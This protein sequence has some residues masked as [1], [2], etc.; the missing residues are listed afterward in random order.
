MGNGLDKLFDIAEEEKLT[1]STEE[2]VEGDSGNPTGEPTSTD[3]TAPQEIKTPEGQQQEEE[4][5]EDDSALV[6]KFKELTGYEGDITDLSVEGISGVVSEIKASIAKQYAIYD[7]NPQIKAVAE[8]ISKGGKLEDF[9]QVPTPFDRA[10]FKEDNEAH[11][12]GVLRTYYKDLKNLSEEEVQEQLDFLAATP[13]KQK[14]RFTQALDAIEANAT[15]QYNDY[16]AR[17]EQDRLKAV[18]DS[19]KLN[20]II[21]A[22]KFQGISIDTKEV[23]AFTSYLKNSE[24]YD[25][26][27]KAFEADPNKV[28]LLEYLVYNDCDLSKLK[29]FTP[30]GNVK[31]ERRTPNLIRTSG[32]VS[33]PKKAVSEDEILDSLRSIK[34]N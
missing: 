24:E 13:D 17:V 34:L 22:G 29:N 25:A 27:W 30:I 2:A 28:A 20:D 15:K 16:T 31:P 32:D 3:P 4:E 6:A 10:V 18:E 11:V 21:I 23:N 7:T 1:G 14:L 26:K 8:W 12:E 33:K 9:T 5:E 19:K